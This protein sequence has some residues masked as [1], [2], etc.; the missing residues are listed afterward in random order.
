MV[1]LGQATADAPTQWTALGI[2]AVVVVYFLRASDR[3][4]S[5]D[6]AEAAVREARIA[7]LEA[8]VEAKDEEILEQRKLKHDA[9][10]RRAAA[11]GTLSLVHD[12]IVKG[13]DLTPIVPLIERILDVPAAVTGQ[14]EADR[15]QMHRLGVVLDRLDAKADLSA[16]AARLV[17]D[18]LAATHE[19]ADAVT[20]G[21]PGAAADAGAQSATDEP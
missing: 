21:E 16:D 3:S 15:K 20:N 7:L 8:R 1:L 9:L 19:R 4:R 5:D 13:R 18:D 10:N 2:V 6:K 12:A 17:K 14:A 11:E